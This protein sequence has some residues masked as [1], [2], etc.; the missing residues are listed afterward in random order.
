MTCQG[1]LRLTTAFPNAIQLG[2][3]RESS[4]NKP[5]SGAT[6]ILVA[7]QGLLAARWPVTHPLDMLFVLPLTGE[8]C[9]GLALM[10]F[11][12][13]FLFVFLFVFVL[14]E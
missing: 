14:K 5:S 4:V 11:F 9:E 7:S 10:G 2:G 6:L 3:D 1:V 8:P 12:V 13:F